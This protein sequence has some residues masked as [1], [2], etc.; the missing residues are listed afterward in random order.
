MAVTGASYLVNLMAAAAFQAHA[1]VA[2]VAAFSPLSL[3]LD[4]AFIA[5]AAGL[6]G[7]MTPRTG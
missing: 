7:T 3:A 1:H 6:L 2:G 4:V 5:A